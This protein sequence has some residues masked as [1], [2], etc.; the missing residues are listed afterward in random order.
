MSGIRT[1]KS[2]RT[3]VT[4][5]RDDLNN[6]TKPTHLVMLYAYNRTGKTRLS[7]E[8]K[9]AGKRK[10]KATPIHSISTPTP[11]ICSPGITIWTATPSA[12]SNS[13]LT[14]VSSM[15]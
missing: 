5:L 8:F 7:M 6:P 12:I 4:R 10:I 11:K 3:L 14:P 1:Y 9:D 13:T 15:A 2:L